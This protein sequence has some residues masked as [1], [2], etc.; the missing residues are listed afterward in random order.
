MKVSKKKKFIKLVFITLLIAVIV[1][2]ILTKGSKTYSNISIARLITLIGII[3]FIFSH[4]IFG[5]KKVWGYIVDNR[6]KLSVILIIISTIIGFF[7]NQIGIVEW[8]K[9]TDVVLSLWWNIKFFSLMLVTYEL[10][11]II[12][13]NNKNVSIIG[14]LV[15]TFSGFVTW[16]FAY[17]APLII[18]EL[19]TV[20]INKILI[21]ENKKQKIICSVITIISSYVY[22]FTFDDYA[23]SFGYIFLALILWILLKNREKLKIKN[24]KIILMVTIITSII[25]AII[26]KSSINYNFMNYTISNTNQKGF[27]GLFNY[28]CNILLPFY[29]GENLKIYGSFLSIFPLPMLWALYY[30]YKNE[31]NSEFLLPI[32]IIAVLETIY[33]VSG[34]PEFIRKLTFLGSVDSVMCMPAVNFAN[35]LIIFYVIENVTEKVFSFKSTIRIT[36]L[37]SIILVFLQRPEMFSNIGFLYLYAV[38]LC[39]LAFLFLNIDD[40]KYRNVFL[41][42]LVVITLIGGVTVNPII[43]DTKEPLEHRVEERLPL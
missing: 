39:L 32:T 1:E 11:Q 36:I 15:V 3:G 18:G 5:F 7:Q 20:L 25:G 40:K 19:I 33:C 35:L 6:Y 26:L 23:I 38:E 21:I 4:F 10:F 28:L 22:V 43:K 12:T 29:D 30:L 34:F 31:E 14:T 13:N 17:I 24:T 27:S 41:F 8:I 9:T 16:N 37:L 2:L 42:F